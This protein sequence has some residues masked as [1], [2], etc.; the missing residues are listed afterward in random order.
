MKQLKAL[1]AMI[2][3]KKKDLIAALQEDLGKPE[4]ECDS[5][6][7]QDKDSQGYDATMLLQHRN[8][9]SA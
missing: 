3:E 2:S 4:S 9:L 6:K 1:K 5:K 7:P 8:G